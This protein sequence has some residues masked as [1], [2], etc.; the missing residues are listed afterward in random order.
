[1]KTAIIIFPGSN[2][3]NEME[4]FL[5]KCTGIKPMMVWHKETRLP[6]VDLYVLPGGF[7]YGDY[8]RAGALANLSPIMKEI[9]RVVK[10]TGKKVL[11]I[12]NGFQ[13]LCEAG[14]LPGTLRINKTQEFIC[15]PVTICRGYDKY[16][17]PIAHA[18]GNYYH[19]HPAEV[20]IAFTYAEDVNG[21]TG[22][23]AGIFNNK[24]NVLGMM[25]HPERA[26]ET[27]HCSQDG[28]NIFKTLYAKSI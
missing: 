11:G 26:F 9:K 16:N 2:C 5:Y 18:E 21:S 3:D 6:D 14:L 22:F 25:P 10:E 27:Y 8:L 15:K 7:S 23:I 28:I 12:C 24:F 4:R 20:S 1:M 19:P 17:I 13:I